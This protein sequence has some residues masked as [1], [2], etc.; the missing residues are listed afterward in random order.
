MKKTPIPVDEVDVPLIQD[1][2]GIWVAECQSI[3]GCVSQG[4]TKSEA[5]K[6]IK[7]ASSLCR[8]V[9]EPDGMKKPKQQK[10]NDRD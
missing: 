9:H 2:E 3:P 10:Q 8:E 7:E 6:N 4:K 5:L 1:E